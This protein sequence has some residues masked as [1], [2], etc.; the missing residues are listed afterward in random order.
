MI[1]H[2]PD[3]AS[4]ERCKDMLELVKERVT[5]DESMLGWVIGKRGAN[6]REMEQE[7]GV[8]SIRVVDNVVEFVGTKFAVMK[9]KL[10]LEEHTAY[11]DEM[12]DAR[13]QVTSLYISPI[14]SLYLQ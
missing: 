5:V 4:V 8:I 1:I 2:G 12:N 6:I 7:T 14:S 13:Q 9:G 11:V 10:W 3:S